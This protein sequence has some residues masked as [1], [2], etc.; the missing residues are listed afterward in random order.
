[1]NELTKVL[2][3]FKEQTNKEITFISVHGIETTISKKDKLLETDDNI[4]RILKENGEIEII[5]FTDN[6]FKIIIK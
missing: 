4:L 2:T 6:I 3:E 5:L 1:M